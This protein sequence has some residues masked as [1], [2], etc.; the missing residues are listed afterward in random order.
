MIQEFMV[1]NFSIFKLN[2]DNINIRILLLYK[3]QDMTLHSFIEM[4]VYFVNAY[5]I[6]II[7]GDFN[8]KPNEEIDS[9]L[10]LYQQMVQEASHLDG[11]ILDHVYI[12]NF[13]EMFHVT[14]SIKSIFFSDHEC[15]KILLTKK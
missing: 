14:V 8:L 6:D 15:I 3:K 2:V 7:T 4:F 12:K 1:D 11:S 5:S 10:N 9:V 13:L